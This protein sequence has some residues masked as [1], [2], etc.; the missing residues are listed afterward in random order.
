MKETLF[1]AA[2]V[3][4]AE[5]A[6]RSDIGLCQ[7]IKTLQLRLIYPLANNKPWTPE[8]RKRHDQLLERIEAYNIAHSLLAPETLRANSLIA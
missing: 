2:S 1:F 8:E 7:D 6:A 5:L 3:R 4:I